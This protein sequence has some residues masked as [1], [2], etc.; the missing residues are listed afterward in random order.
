MSKRDAI[1]WWAS[2][3]FVAALLLFAAT[4]N[5]FWL[6]LMIASYLLRPTLASLGIGRAKIDER[7]MTINYRSGNIAFAVTLMLCAFCAAKLELEG[8]HAFEL[9]AMVIILGLATKALFNVILVKNYREAATK[10][11]ISVGL[12]IALFSVMDA[13][14]FLSV[15]MQILPG[16]AIAGIGLLSRK[17]PRPIGIVVFAATAILLWLILHRG[18]GWGQLATAAVICIP[19]GL[20]GAA[21]FVRDKTEGDAEPANSA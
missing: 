19:L 11:I 8:D 18:T 3:I 21:L 17:Y 15:V 6:A 9:F 10:I 1:F 14:S 20:A 2:A 5:Q 7:Q 13:S 16:L 4:Q 12:L